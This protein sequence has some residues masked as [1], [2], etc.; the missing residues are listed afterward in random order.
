MSHVCTVHSA[1]DDIVGE[2]QRPPS[3]LSRAIVVVGEVL[4]SC[5]GVCLFFER[6][7]NEV[8]EL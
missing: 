3:S 1:L 2:K 5:R 6:L 4:L 7:R 8:S